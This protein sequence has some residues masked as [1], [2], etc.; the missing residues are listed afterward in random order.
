[1]SQL[2]KATNRKIGVNIFLIGLSLGSKC[3]LQNLC[4]C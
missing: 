1:L 4:H 3:N 2:I